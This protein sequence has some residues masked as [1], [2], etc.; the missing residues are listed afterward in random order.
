MRWQFQFTGVNT[1]KYNMDYDLQSARK[2]IEDETIVRFYRWEPYCISLGANQDESSVDYSA[3]GKDNI[4]IVKRPTGG[5]AI[6][7]AD[8]I[9]YSVSTFIN[10][11][12]SAREIYHSINQAL[13]EGLKIF[14]S[15]LSS[16]EME[17]AQPDFQ[18]FYKQD[19]STLCFAVPAKSELK[20]K[21][22]KLAGS[23]QRKLGKS[24]LQHGSLLC[25]PEHK[26]IVRYLHLENESL[27]KME[28][29]LDHHTTDLKEILGEVIDYDELVNCL[30]EGF[31]RH[32]QIEDFQTDE[33]IQKLQRLNIT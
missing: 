18:Q 13:I 26:K 28:E 14:D 33:A 2:I 12:T 31:V 11:E 30:V 17:T 19:V 15:R 21:G 10:S 5:R 23:A 29:E 32:Y 27:K 25:G 7:H 9:T 6:L 4:D 22:K 24:L 16:V 8:E 20:F 3:A 1:G